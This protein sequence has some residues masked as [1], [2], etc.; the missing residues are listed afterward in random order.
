MHLIEHV[1]EVKGHDRAVCPRHVHRIKRRRP[2]PVQGEFGQG[3][4]TQFATLPEKMIHSHIMHQ[5]LWLVCSQVFFTDSN[6]FRWKV[7]YRSFITWCRR[8]WLERS[9]MVGSLIYVSLVIFCVGQGNEH[10][11]GKHGM[12][13][14]DDELS[15]H[16]KMIVRF[17]ESCHLWE[18]C[19]MVH[20]RCGGRHW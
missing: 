7:C 20:L 9:I 11:F 10:L 8:G 3:C 16:T 18:K 6:S 14:V 4:K 15:W 19:V 12:K 13:A 5:I 17:F 1:T 2:V